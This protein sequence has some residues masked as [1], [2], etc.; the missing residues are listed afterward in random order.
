MLS[1]DAD[2][3]DFTW[4]TSRKE[5]RGNRLT[6]SALNASRLVLMEKFVIE[7]GRGQPERV[8][9]I[10]NRILYS[11]QPALAQHVAILLAGNLL[12]HF[13]NQFD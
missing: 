4:K 8:F 11:N 13:E 10:F 7:D 9:G 2:G 6:H 5:D 12:G 1:L 3:H